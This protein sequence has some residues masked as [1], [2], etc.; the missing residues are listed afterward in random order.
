MS[1][2]QKGFHCLSLGKHLTRSK[3]EAEL[4]QALPKSHSKSK[5]EPMYAECEGGMA[6]SNVAMEENPAYQSV[7]VQ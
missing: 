6:N 3:G 2:W 1:L 5:A 4:N 7:D